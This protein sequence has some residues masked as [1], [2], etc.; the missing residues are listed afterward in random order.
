MTLQ[1]I[2][3]CNVMVFV[4][5]II[6]NFSFAYISSN[7][8]TI[9]VETLWQRWTAKK[10]TLSDD[11]LFV[12]HLRYMHGL[13]FAACKHVNSSDLNS[14][15]FLKLPNQR[16]FYVSLLSHLSWVSEE[17]KTRTPSVSTFTTYNVHLNC[18]IP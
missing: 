10:I 14:T 4:A 12:S 8:K 9:A 11:S 13:T 18:A 1:T 5:F 17:Y 7:S 16:L 15:A 2:L 3:P 6:C